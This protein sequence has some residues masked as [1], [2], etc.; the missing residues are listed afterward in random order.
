M[1]LIDLGLPQA[2]D[3]FCEGA[4]N[5]N[6]TRMKFP[7]GAS[8]N[9]LMRL[10]LVLPKEVDGCGGGARLFKNFLV[11][12]QESPVIAGV[13]ARDEVGCRPPGKTL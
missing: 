8:A 7:G 1:C 9:M 3:C 2:L 11:F 13:L 6:W 10:A 4:R 12:A 5:W